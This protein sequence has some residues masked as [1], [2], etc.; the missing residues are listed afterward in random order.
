MP[1]YS[2]LKSEVMNDPTHAGYT[3]M[4]DAQVAASL[5]APVPVQGPVPM[6]SVLIWA[7]QNNVMGR[8]QA[9]ANSTTDPLQSAALAVLAAL[10]G[11]YGTL[12]V[13]NSAVLSMLQAFQNAGDFT[14]T[15]QAALLA[16]GQ[17]TTTRAL[18]LAGWGVPVQAPDILAVRGS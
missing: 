12:D 13:T 10:Q 18:S 16:L 15:A 3:T 8:M 5:N 14:A 2:V 6:T 7:A 9:H 11:G 1:D 4:T 17:T